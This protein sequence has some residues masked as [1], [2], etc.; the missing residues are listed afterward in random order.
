V[1]SKFFSAIPDIETIPKQTKTRA[2]IKPKVEFTKERGCDVCPLKLSWRTISTPRMPLSGNTRSG[3]I[4]VL[5]G[6]PLEE[7]DYKGTQLKSPGGQLFRKAI[8]ARDAGRLVYQN[9]VRCYTPVD[10]MPPQAIHACGEHLEADLATLPIKAIIGIGQQALHRVFP[11]AKVAQ[12]W[13]LHGLR[14]AAQ[15]GN[16]VYWYLPVNDMSAYLEQ[17][18]DRNPEWDAEFSV[19]KAELKTFFREVDKWGKPR[20]ADLSTDLVLMP[21]TQSEAMALLTKMSH[22]IA[23]DLETTDLKPYVFGAKVLTAAFSDG[24]TTFAVPIGHREQVTAWGL[25][26]LRHV[27][28]SYPLLA[29]SASMEYVWVRHLF[30]DADIMP[31]EDSRATARLYFQRQHGTGLAVVSRIMLGVN[32]KALSDLDTTRLDEYPVEEVLIYNG[33]DALASRLCYDKQRPHVQD[34]GYNRIVEA[35]ESTV[36]MELLGLQVDQDAVVDLRKQWLAK[37]QAAEAAAH[38]I[39]EVKAWQA[40]VGKEFDIGSNDRIG[41]VLVNYAHIMLPKT[42]KGNIMTGEDTL[43]EYASEHPLVQT[44]LEYREAQKQIST[45]IDPCGMVSVRYPDGLLHPSYNTMKTATLRLSCVSGDTVLETTRGSFRFDEYVPQ[46]GDK[47]LTHKGR[48]RQVLRKIYKGLAPQ[49]RIVLG[50]GAFIVCTLEH[51]V[52]TRTGWQRIGDLNL[53]DEVCSYGHHE[54]ISDTTK[55][56][57]G[58]EG[59][60]REQE[61]HSSRVGKKARGEYRNHNLDPEGRY[62]TRDIQSR[63]AAEVSA[64]QAR[65]E[66]PYV[67]QEWKITSSL[68]K[69]LRGR[70]W[71]HNYSYRWRTLPKTPGSHGRFAWDACMRTSVQLGCSSY[72][73]E[74]A[75]QRSRQPSLDDQESSS[76]NASYQVIKSIVYVGKI[77]VWDIEVDEDHSYLCQGLIHHNSENPNIQNFPKRKNREIRR[78]IIPGKG[79][80]IVPID[81]GQLEARIIAM[82]SRDK[83]LCQSIING[84]DIHSVWLNKVL[85]AYPDYLIRLADKTGETDE[86][87]IRKG[88][89]TIIKTDFVF[90]SF[91]GSS[92]KSCARKTGV[93]LKIME[94]IAEE[95]WYV[96]RGVKR[97]IDTQRSNYQQTGDVP[98]ITGRVRHAVVPGNEVINNPIQGVA[99]DIVLEAQNELSILSRQRKDPYL[100]PRINVHD[101]ITFILPNSDEEIARYIEEIM[102]IMVKVRF[103]WQIVPLSV[104]CS[105]GEKNWADVEELTTYTGDYVR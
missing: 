9:L 53:G 34:R 65:R 69:G 68:D 6:R 104:E 43:K 105:L 19:L 72:R 37:M 75:E 10:S 56:G 31:F 52:L 99:A 16:K 89:R 18:R 87:K 22:P 39:F 1:P 33:L 36:E 41:E 92:A 76:K 42:S 25:N 58:E 15:I 2:K 85:E 71:L 70:A 24:R 55:Q 84:E 98:T 35:N 17:G 101:D 14:M 50:S 20:I 100:H 102:P 103:P 88:G 73:Q 8:P 26:V 83:V 97:W 45:Y 48:L 91:Y 86:K 79:H 54:N 32:V 74:Q 90:A 51:R 21:K 27:V 38:E 95:F 81:F 67:G 57:F 7:D 82:V 80:V 61:T 78:I 28:T 93:P 29:H 13:M 66:E 4:L 40:A 59:I 3:D 5:G 11:D 62:H 12:V 64:E 63:E 23:V 46:E 44:V 47:V 30:P 49:Y 77:A 60:S 96:H 94:G